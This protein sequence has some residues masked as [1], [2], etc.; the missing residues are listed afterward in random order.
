[1]SESNP[2]V[3]I[4]GRI[5][6]GKAPANIRA[7]AAHGALPL[8]RPTLVRL[9]I[10]LLKDPDEEIR[11]SA[12][13]ALGELDTQAIR[14]VLSDRSI[15]GEVIV[16]F[17][18]LAAREETLAERVAFHPSAPLSAMAVLAATGSAAI[19]EL[20]LTNEERLLVEPV[21]LE[22]LML[23]PALRTD[24]RGRILELLQRV[25]K[26]QQRQAEDQQEADQA[27]E[28]ATDKTLTEDLEEVARLLEVDVGELLSASEILDPEEFEES[29]E[30][31]IRDAYRKIL[32][33]NT[34][35]KAI[36]AMKGNREER[37]I[38]IR[39]SNR[40]VSVGVLRNG[41]I[42]EPEIESIAKMRNVNDGV[43]RQ[44]GSSREWTKN[45]TVI[46]SLIHN[47]RTPQ[48]ISMNFVK[49]LVTR[50]LKFL[51]G[52][53]E[54]PELIRRMARRTLDTRTQSQR[55]SFKKK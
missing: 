29:D 25:S 8:P 21:L 26:N 6:D 11:D 24:Q 17:A 4:V 3:E 54:V 42:T 30:P 33:L 16:H 9:Q 2:F 13:A 10:F 27:G 35:Q 20:V 49:R 5:L 32:R 36:L 51:V 55:V 23:N 31:E 18:K 40:T 22:R 12:K 47:P 7:A 45:Y 41:R 52:S 1:L 37:M 53:R 38:L 48:G 44:V 34:A 14:E 50:D 43:L 19:I 28:V 15:P 46:L 39:D